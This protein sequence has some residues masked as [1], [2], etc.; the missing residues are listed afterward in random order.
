MG[1]AKNAFICSQIVGKEGQV[2]GVDQNPDMLAVSRSA[3]KKVTKNIGFNNTEFLEGSIEK[4]DE[5]DKDLNS[6]IADKSVDIILSN[7]VLNLVSPESRNN[8]LRNIKRVLKDN[9]RIAIS[10][11]VSNKKVP[12]R[13]QNDHDLWTG[14]ISG[15]WHEPE[16]L[17]DFKDLGFKNLEFA[18]R[19]N[20][21]WK[22]IEDIEFRT[23]TLVGNI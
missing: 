23:V 9:G 17:N 5:L 12:L 7:C 14:C 16:F 21:P 1:A 4:L 22:V 20:E 13:L 2:I 15:A 18:E 10:D 6:L 19:S 3:S 11:I 8:L